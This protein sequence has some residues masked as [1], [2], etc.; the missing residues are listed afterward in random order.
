MKM[1]KSSYCTEAH[2][3]HTA[4]V[5]KCNEVSSQPAAPSRLPACVK[6]NRCYHLLLP[7]NHD[8]YT[9][10]CHLLQ[11]RLRLCSPVHCS[12]IM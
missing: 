1:E 3:K 10:Q 6:H 8:L 4:N 9:K 5:R 12:M 2:N 7:S 11:H